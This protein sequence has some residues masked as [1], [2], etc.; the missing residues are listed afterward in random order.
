MDH[1]DDHDNDDDTGGALACAVDL[2]SGSALP[3]L[4]SLYA[5]GQ[6]GD[7]LAGAALSLAGAAAALVASAVGRGLL[8][9]S[10]AESTSVGEWEHA[11]GAVLQLVGAALRAVLS[12]AQLLAQAG[13]LDADVGAGLYAVPVFTLLSMQGGGARDNKGGASARTMVAVLSLLVL[14]VGWTTSVYSTA[15][16]TLR[17]GA[18]PP[19]NRADNW[20]W[21][22]LFA[23]NAAF[24]CSD[25]GKGGTTKTKATAE[26]WA[27]G[28][29]AYAARGLV[30]ACLSL[31]PR[32]LSLLLTERQP[33]WLF[34]FQNVL[35]IHS[36]ILQASAARRMLAGLRLPAPLDGFRVEHPQR[37]L[38]VWLAPALA[39]A[40]AFQWRDPADASRAVLAL[41]ALRVALWG[42]RRANQ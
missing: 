17:L 23:S 30:F 5:L 10:E 19:G 24:A 37:T 25:A 6:G 32:A 35:L 11:L 39:T 42:V 20:W 12:V 28:W 36:A 40:Y 41:T 16:A 13:S 3:L 38:M 1:D 22:V 34:V 18:P 7:Q 21:Y 9:A 4:Y 15:P 14:L 33:R 27:S 29:P 26:G 31:A 2:V 8:L